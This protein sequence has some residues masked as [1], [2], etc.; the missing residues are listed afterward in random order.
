[1]AALEI[2]SI[3]RMINIT[4]TIHSTL[5]ACIFMIAVFIKHFIDL[6]VDCLLSVLLSIVRLGIGYFVKF[7]HCVIKIHLLV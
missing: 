7:V 1:M 3:F 5:T 4:D 2:G 6:V